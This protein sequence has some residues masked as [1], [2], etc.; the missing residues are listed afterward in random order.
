MSLF[1]EFP[2]ICSK[3]ITIALPFHSFIPQLLHLLLVVLT[4]NFLIDLVLAVP[5]LIAASDLWS[6]KHCR[7][8]YR[9]LAL[10]LR[11]TSVVF[12]LSQC[13]HLNTTVFAGAFLRSARIRSRFFSQNLRSISFR[14][15]LGS[16]VSVIEPLY[17]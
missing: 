7:E 17:T 16:V 9:C 10:L 5:L 15:A 14:L 1:S 8:Q 3:S 12:S 11:F 13:K 6:A 4:R 2:S